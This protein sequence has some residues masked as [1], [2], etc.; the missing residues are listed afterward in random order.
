[1]N[2]DWTSPSIIPLVACDVFQMYRNP[3]DQ[4]VFDAKDLEMSELMQI[5]I[6]YGLSWISLD[7]PGYREMYAQTL[8]K[9]SGYQFAESLYKDVA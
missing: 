4:E 5:S 6:E 7:N 3:R 8:G 9:F 1:M 2:S